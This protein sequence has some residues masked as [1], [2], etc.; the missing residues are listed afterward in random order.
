MLSVIPAIF[1]ARTLYRRRFPGH[2][3]LLRLCTMMLILPVLVAIFGILSVY[4]RQ[5]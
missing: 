1:L 5:D 2:M 3:V 4:G